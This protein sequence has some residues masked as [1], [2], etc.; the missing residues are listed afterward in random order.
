MEM[1]VKKRKE[2]AK[3]PNEWISQHGPIKT[4]HL[5]ET[6]SRDSLLD[7]ERDETLWRMVS[8]GPNHV[9]GWEFTSSE[10]SDQ[11]KKTIETLIVGGVGKGLCRKCGREGH[12]A[13]VCQATTKAPWL[14]ALSPSLGSLLA[15]QGE[16]C[17]SNI[18]RGS[19]EQQRSVRRRTEEEVVCFRCGRPGHFEASCYARSHVNGGLL[20]DNLHPS[21][22]GGETEEDDEQE[23]EEDEDEEEGEE[24]D[25]E[26]FVCFRCGRH[27]HFEA[28][29]YARSDVNGRR[30]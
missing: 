20:Q 1:D 23:E 8:H 18:S 25:E 10:L 29:C 11:N 24:D 7:W 22:A 5:P 28:S 2:H 27:G 19:K 21:I 17:N 12:F 4:R 16:R 15:S 13:G 9:R 3:R 26:E 30:L 14:N 6:A